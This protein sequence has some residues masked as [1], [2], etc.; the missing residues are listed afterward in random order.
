[1]R[2]KDF[3]TLSNLIERECRDVFLTTKL[4]KAPFLAVRQHYPTF[5]SVL[6]IKDIDRFLSTIKY[7]TTECFCVD[8]D[9]QIDVSEFATRG[10]VDNRK[11]LRL[12][13]GGA[14]IILN[15]VH[16]YHQPL[17]AL[18][19]ALAGELSAPCQANVYLTPPNAKGL[20]VHYDTHDV[21][22]IQIAGAKAWRVYDSAINLPLAG[23]GSEVQITST[24]APIIDTELRAGQVLYIPRGWTHDAVTT[25]SLSLHVTLG[26]F[27]YTWADAILE[28][29][30]Y[31]VLSDARFRTT[32]PLDFLTP[33]A[34][35]TLLNARFRSVL[36]E[37][38][39]QSNIEIA[40]HSL[41]GQYA[42]Q[43]QPTT[44][45]LLP[46]LE[47]SYHLSD[48]TVVR[49]KLLGRDVI[50]NTATMVEI[51]VPGGKLNIDKSASDVVALCLSGR[52]VQLR[53]LLSL[54][55]AENVH[56][57]IRRLVAA[58]ALEI[59]S[60]RHEDSNSSPS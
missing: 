59:I 53:E 25:S 50:T 27:F 10:V 55:P 42:E 37:L 44:E 32:L 45:G 28:Y 15:R 5:E 16:T 47:M 43:M 34:D 26:V 11:A 29:V 57:L 36:S 13:G 3:S 17:G 33:G 14:T 39:D 40:K 23:Q 35:A 24:A 31:R 60:G 20:K 30:S 38:A 2:P 22:I 21:F 46:Q 7:R 54:L 6:S 12:Y 52:P 18:C 9:H 1:M 4:E 56:E 41:A 8:G 49:A 58:E 51:A 19:G 48:E